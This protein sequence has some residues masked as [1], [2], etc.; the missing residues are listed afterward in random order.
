M[1]GQDQEQEQWLSDEN[2]KGERAKVSTPSL[3][4]DQVGIAMAAS[5]GT[6]SSSDRAEESE[7][8]SKFDDL[9]LIQLIVERGVDVSTQR[10]LLILCC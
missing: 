6:D 9:S 7:V 10:N 4:Q 5:E 8:T 2:D 1:Q 3:V